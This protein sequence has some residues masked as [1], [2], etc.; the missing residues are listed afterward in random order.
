MCYIRDARRVGL[1]AAG[2]EVVAGDYEAPGQFV[3][4]ALSQPDSNCLSDLCIAEFSRNVVFGTP[5]PAASKEARAV[6]LRT[7][8]ESLG[9]SRGTGGKQPVVRDSRPSL[10]HRLDADDG[11]SGAQ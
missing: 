2:C 6:V 10:S 11:F 8:T 4:A 9:Q 3:A 5:E 7:D 1:A